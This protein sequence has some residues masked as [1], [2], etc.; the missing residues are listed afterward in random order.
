LKVVAGRGSL[1]FKGR[2]LKHMGSKDHQR[3]SYL[4]I[5]QS[6]EEVEKIILGVDEESK[7]KV[8][9]ACKKEERAT[10]VSFL[11]FT[12]ILA[13]IAGAVLLADMLSAKFFG[14]H[15][16]SVLLGGLAGFLAAMKR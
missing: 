9:E 6:G 8:N 11:R 4:V 1:P 3:I 5:E 10:N 7:L 16:V 15:I 2:R 12:I 13:S 14:D